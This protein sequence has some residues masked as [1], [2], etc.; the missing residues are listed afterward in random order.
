MK[1]I[2]VVGNGG[3]AKE[4]KW[5]IERIN[6]TKAIWN[7]KGFIN[8]EKTDGIIGNDHFLLSY[9]HELY[10]VIAIGEP[11]IREKLYH[12]YKENPN[13]HFPNIIDPSVFISESISI[14]KG[15]IICANTVL[16]VDISVGDFCIINLGCTVGHGTVIRDFVTINPGTNVSGNVVLNNLV[17]LGTGT[18]IIQGK[19]IG[20]ETQTGAGA[21]VVNNL[22]E[23][24]TAVG[25]PAKPV[26]YRSV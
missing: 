4:T 24:C 2:V 3:F 1:D 10:V 8:K 18:K 14:G 20:Y 25:V 12:L 7:F 9:S 11:C 19:V 13:I 26:K 22:P 15:N 21:V 5:L 23:N 16:T 17:N 6:K